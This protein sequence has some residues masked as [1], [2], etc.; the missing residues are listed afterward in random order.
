MTENEMMIAPGTELTPVL[1]ERLMCQMAYLVRQNEAKLQVEEQ[2][3]TIANLQGYLA[4]YRRY[5]SLIMAAGFDFDYRQK[6]DIECPW[7][8]DDDK[9]DYHDLETIH[10]LNAE[11]QRDEIYQSLKGSI[12]TEV[13]SKKDFLFYTSDKA[14]DM[15]WCKGWYEAISQVESW[16][17][18]LENSYIWETKAK[19][20]SLPF[21]D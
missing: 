14:R 3:A 6:H 7:V 15:H 5:G 9:P 4:S 13:N 18:T 19:A 20:E 11:L 21:D 12:E 1:L 16:I 17:E 8:I 10:M 2:G